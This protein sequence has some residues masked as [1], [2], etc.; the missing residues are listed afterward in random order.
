MG[1]GNQIPTGM[2][3]VFAVITSL[4]FQAGQSKL[5]WLII[6]IGGLTLGIVFGLRNKRNNDKKGDN[7]EKQ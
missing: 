3:I 2:S 7:N 1:K 4:L 6:V 5:A